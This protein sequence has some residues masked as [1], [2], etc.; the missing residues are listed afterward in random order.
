MLLLKV[1]FDNI[2]LAFESHHSM[3]KHSGNDDFMAVKLDISKAYDKVEWLYLETVMRKMGFANQWIKLIML[4]VTSVLYSILINGEPK[5]RSHP[6]RGIR[7]RDPLSPFLFLLYT[8]GLHGLIS[9]EAYQGD[10]WGYSLPRN[11]P[12]LTHLLFTDDSLL[13]CRAT[14]Q[15]C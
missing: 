13:F 12:H 6:S 4:C 14:M 11:S 9:K 8:K 7:Q 2:L 5:G 3:Q 15:E 10:I 1:G